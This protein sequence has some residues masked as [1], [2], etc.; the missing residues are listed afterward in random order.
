MTAEA[1][2]RRVAAERT[3]R[4]ERLELRVSP[5][6]KQLLSDAAAV[7]ARTI[8]QF[9]MQSAAIAAQDVLADRTLFVI[10]EAQWDAFAAALDREPRSLP[11]LSTLLTEPSVLDRG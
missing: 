1:P 7:T 11:R 9:V 6:E 3:T 10:S 2:L 8:T 5:E 4:S